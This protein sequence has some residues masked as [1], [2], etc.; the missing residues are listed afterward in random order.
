MDWLKS[1]QV[2]SWVSVKWVWF[3]KLC[4]SQIPRGVNLGSL[5][6]LA[7][8][9][10]AVQCSHRSGSWKQQDLLCFRESKVHLVCRH[11]GSQHL[12]AGQTFAFGLCFELRCTKES[13]LL[14]WN[15]SDGGVKFSFG[16]RLKSCFYFIKPTL[17]K[18]NVA[19]ILC[20]LRTAEMAE[21]QQRYLGALKLRKS[22]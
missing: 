1:L 12:P 3:C 4:S 5:W 6:A 7:G 16:F 15:R 19:L 14:I 20:W 11:L 18:K 9:A 21:Q 22:W 17:R 10:C 8:S 13:I 2:L